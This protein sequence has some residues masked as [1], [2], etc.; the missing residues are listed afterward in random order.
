[1]SYI[2]IS[3]QK[4][5]AR[6]IA[7]IIRDGVINDP[8][9]RFNHMTD[10][11]VHWEVDGERGVYACNLFFPTKWGYQWSD[12]RHRSQGGEGHPDEGK[13]FF[14]WRDYNNWEQLNEQDDPNYRDPE[15]LISH[16]RLYVFDGS[17]NFWDGSTPKYGERLLDWPDKDFFGDRSVPNGCL[18]PDNETPTDRDRRHTY[19]RQTTCVWGLLNCHCSS[20]G[21]PC[22]KVETEFY[23]NGGSCSCGF[24]ADIHPDCESD[25]DEDDETDTYGYSTANRVWSLST[26]QDQ[27][28]GARMARLGEE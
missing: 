16:H 4:R 2:P 23:R 25:E 13:S 15:W 20:N 26:N 17:N 28:L 5:G 6:Q 21:A 12:P 11:D 7:I 27:T 14:F 3:L 10:S 9:F 1:M 22:H 24:G 18:S 19:Y 8:E